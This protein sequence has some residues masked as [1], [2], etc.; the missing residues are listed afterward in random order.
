MYDEVLPNNLE[1][2]RRAKILNALLENGANVNAITTN[3]K[4]TP[5]H[6]SVD[7]SSTCP[8]PIPG[9]R[10]VLQRADEENQNHHPWRNI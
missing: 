4:D 10:A 3:D 5:L 2:F 6:L 8:R 9:V 7:S 1:H